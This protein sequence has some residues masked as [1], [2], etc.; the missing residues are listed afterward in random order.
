MA[1][2]IDIDPSAGVC[3]G[4]EKAIATA[5]EKLREGKEVYGLGEMVHNDQETGRLAQLGLK[6]ISAEDLDRIGPARV[7]LRAHGEPPSTFRK[8]AANGIEI[9]DATCP[10]VTSLQKRIRR[11]YET[12][13]KQKEQ[14]VIFGKQGH[15]ETI[16]LMGQTNDE[17]LLVTTPGKIDHVDPLKKVYLYSQTTMDPDRFDV[18][19]ANLEAHAASAHSEKPQAHCSICNQMKRRKPDLKKFAMSHEYMVFVSGKQSSNGK[20]LFEYCR[21]VNPQTYWIHTI[22]DIDPGWF[23]MGAEAGKAAANRSSRKTGEPGS[24]KVPGSTVIP[25]SIGISGATST[26]RWQLEQVRQYLAD[27]ITD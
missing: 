16:G 9:I 21:Q 18:L 23:T 12:L 15:P 27:L 10:I 11:C 14:I 7:I 24:L 8:A 26:P 22:A 13:D 1:R 19:K 6:T 20:M 25:G 5:E 4:V 17:A 2:I 3:F